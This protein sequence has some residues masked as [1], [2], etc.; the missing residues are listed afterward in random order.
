[1]A[2]RPM[3]FLRQVLA[4]QIGLLVLVVGVGF[5]LVGWLLD[6]T[7]V[8]QYGQR[9]L[10][11]ARSVAADGELGE[12][13]ATH[14]DPDHLIQARAERVR[15]AT[16]AL[17]VVVT[18][19]HGLRLAHPNPDNLGKPVGTDPSGPLAGREVVN[20]ERST[21]GLSV[22]GKVP[23]R[24][25]ADR[26]VGEVSVGFDVDEVDAAWLGLLRLA[27]PFAGGALL[28]GVAGSTR[29]IRLLKRRTLGLEPHELAELMREREAVLYGI[30]EG[31]LAV[32]TNGHVSM[33]N[34]EAARLLGVDVV[35]GAHVDTLDLPPRLRAA[36]AGEGA[37]DN[38]LAVAG[39]RV[40]VAN[41]RVVWRDGID[42]GRVLTLRDRTDL[43]TLTRELDSVRG[44]T[45]ALRAQRHEFANRLH[46]LSGLLQTN[47]TREAVEYLQAL[48]DGPVTALGADA[49][50][51]RDPY[52][53]AFLSAKTARA[54]EKAVTLE[55]DETSWVP[56]KVVAPVE[57]TT[58]LGNLVDNAL[59]AARLG[60]RRPARVEV[61]LLAD[62]R[63]LHVSV[64]DSGDGVSNRLRQAIFAQGVSTRDGESRGLG[65][66]LARQAARSLGGDVELADPG[67]AEHGAVFVARLPEVLAESVPDAAE[68]GS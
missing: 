27:G 19:D 63:T 32:D 61:D 57:V 41:Q 2:R 20:A 65:L 42:L 43:E 46:T 55:V 14:H 39:D 62:G 25:R 16:G 66:A 26:I 35:R 1:M 54:Q 68:V 45:D 48:S 50:A 67:G 15:L 29:L 31:V 24:D 60:G 53:Q 6:R 7:L 17:F 8:D 28:L 37:A 38:L 56:T 22:R 11:V 51:I 30:G 40:L 49:E 10:A 33:C 58:V 23:L 3:P 44:L 59:E 47:H 5:A 52:L 12:V 13:A 18:D 9:A 64:A 36:L 4:L 34:R 21:L